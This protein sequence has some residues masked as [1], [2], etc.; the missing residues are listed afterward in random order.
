MSILE[1]KVY[2]LL[3]EATKTLII[4]NNVAVKIKDNIS[5]T[6]PL[7]HS[8]SKVGRVMETL[9][10]HVKPEDEPVIEKPRFTTYTSNQRQ[11]LDLENWAEWI[12]LA[13]LIWKKIKKRMA[14]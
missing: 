11:E 8:I 5:V 10:S 7:F 1:L 14:I 9:L 2:P 4:I 12:G 13:I 6:D 3:D